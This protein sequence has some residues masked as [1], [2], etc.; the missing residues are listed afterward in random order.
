MKGI[1]SPYGFNISEEHLRFVI[2]VIVG[3]MIGV[4]ARQLGWQIAGIDL[5]YLVLFGLV[6]AFVFV[7][8]WELIRRRSA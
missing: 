3:M 7:G 4:L 1:Q 5:S 6:G 2:S 8:L